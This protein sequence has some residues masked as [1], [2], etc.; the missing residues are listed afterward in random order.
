MKHEDPAAGIEVPRVMAVLQSCGVELTTEQATLLARHAELVLEANQHINLT[1]ITAP[2]DVMRLH[3][4]DS[5]MF[6]NLVEPL[7]GPILDV[8]SGAGYPGIPLAIMGYDVQLCESVK[9]KAAFLAGSVQ[10]LNLPVQVHAVRAEELAATAPGQY[11]TVVFRA[12]SSLASLVELASPLLRDGA[13]AIALKAAVTEDE[14]RAGARAGSLCG[15][16]PV[17]ERRYTLPSGEN[18]TVLVYERTGSA[19]T[20]LPRRPGLAQNH[21]LG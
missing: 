2:E 1:R 19:S 15:M 20:R 11:N 13:R 3:L 18:R 12:V 5:L 10:S 17:D 4:A 9:K 21:P 16:K 6:V 7:R 8:G 14:R